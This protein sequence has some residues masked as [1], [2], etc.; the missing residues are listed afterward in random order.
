ME[1]GVVYSSTAVNADPLPGGT[2]VTKLT[3]LTETA[4][5]RRTSMIPDQGTGG[6]H[7]FGM[8][9]VNPV[10]GFIRLTVKAL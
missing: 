1:R 9:V 2:G 10:P 5:L 7:T 3:E 8:P 4:G 6:R